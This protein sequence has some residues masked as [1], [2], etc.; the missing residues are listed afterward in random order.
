MA[1]SKPANVDE[2]IASFPHDTQLV[3]KQVRLTIKKVLPGA[4]E[5]ISYSI[6]AFRVNGRNLVYFAGFKNHVGLYPVPRE[7]KSF[8]KDFS[9][10]KTSGKGTIQFPLGK[11]LPLD[12][13]TRIVKFMEKRALQKVAK[14]K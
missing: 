13:I 11:P 14:P 6:P 7:T 5:I 1:I 8:E 12:L 9:Q 3:L 4:E 2:Y 10:Y